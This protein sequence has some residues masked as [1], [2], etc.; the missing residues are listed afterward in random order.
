MDDRRRYVVRRHRVGRSPST[1]NCAEVRG[2]GTRID[3]GDLDAV[4]PDLFHDS[5]AEAPHAELRGVVG[6]QGGVSEKAGNGGDIDD[7]PSECAYLVLLSHVWEDGARTEK[8]AS[9]VRA[10]LYIPV[11]H[12]EIIHTPILSEAGI[13][14][15]HVDSSGIVH[16]LFDGRRDPVLV[17]DVA[18]DG[19]KGLADRLARLFESVLRSRKAKDLST[20]SDEMPGKSQTDA[21]AGAGHNCHFISQFHF[22]EVIDACS[23][24]CPLRVYATP[25]SS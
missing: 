20:S 18:D 13:V 8:D 12:G 17:A 3:A 14:D 2:D 15:E 21:G 4:I 5:L 11:F 1:R 10:H 9:Q 19:M 25:R 16:Y 22:P 23:D 7:V 6:A 24:E